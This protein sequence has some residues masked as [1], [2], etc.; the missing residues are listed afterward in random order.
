MDFAHDYFHLPLKSGGEDR[1]ETHPQTSNAVFKFRDFEHAKK[2]FQGTFEYYAGMLSGLK[3]VVVQ[4]HVVGLN[5]AS[6]TPEKNEKMMGEFR[7]WA[8]QSVKENGKNGAAVKVGDCGLCEGCRRMRKKWH[9]GAASMMEQAYFSFGY[10]FG[11][12]GR[13]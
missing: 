3:E 8:E 2:R 6:M 5:M 9:D 11:S 4:L 1:W 13:R 12:T 7:A 10:T